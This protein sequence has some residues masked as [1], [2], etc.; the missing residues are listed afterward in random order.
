MGDWFSLCLHYVHRI[1]ATAGKS[2]G[3]WQREGGEGRGMIPEGFW[4]L[5]W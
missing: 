2:I 5:G 3:T 1:L 4:S